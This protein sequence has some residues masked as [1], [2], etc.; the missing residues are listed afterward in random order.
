[1]WN[2]H[3]IESD[4]PQMEQ[5]NC[6]STTNELYAALRKNYVDAIAGHEAMLSSLVQDSEGAYRMLKESPYTSE[7]GVA[8]QKGTH[9]KV[10]AN[11]TETLKEMQDEGITGEIVTKDDKKLNNTLNE[12]F[13]FVK[14]RIERYETYNTN[15]Q[16]K[17]LVRLMDKTTE[18]SRVI[19]QER[20]LSAE[21]LDEYAREQRL[22]GILVLDQKL[23]VIVQSAEDGD[24][25]PLWQKLIESEYV[26]DIADHPK[27]TY[28]T[29]LRNDGKIYDFAAV[30][31]QDTAG[32]LIAY[33]QKEE[34]DML[35][36]AHQDELIRQV[37]SEPFQEA[38]REFINISTV[39][40]WKN[41]RR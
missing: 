20:I 40:V 2:F 22:T 11:L 5:V 3:K 30:A 7:V 29:R 35:S 21:M 15:D 12:T 28:T 24:T 16:V 4:L 19:A 9:E 38:Y 6:F 13:D 14:N 41:V 17:S 10:A 1:M 26:R 37:I 25:M 18:L 34:G 32:I 31:R 36:R 8:F 33:A 23:K 39:A 27:K